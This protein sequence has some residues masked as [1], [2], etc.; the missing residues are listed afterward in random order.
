MNRVKKEEIRKHKEARQGLTPEQVQVLDAQDI[1][2]ALIEALARKMHVARF[3]E[4][5]DYMYDS[6]SDAR[7]RQRGVNPMSQEYMA[8]IKE[9]RQQQGVSPLAENGLALTQETNELCLQEAK[10]LIDS[11]RTRID[12]ILFYK[13]DPIRISNANWP[14]DEY[15]SY[16]PEV[17]QLAINS[18]SYQPLAEHL[19]QLSKDI[20]ERADSQERAEAVA[21]LIFSIVNEEGHYPEHN[22]AVVD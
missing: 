22:T 20:I 15:S 19:M 9:K 16:V 1:E 10:G 6:T 4:E 21:E 18:S 11:L 3:A 17:L 2:N 7:E 8:K 5:Y 13:W 12:E 14:R